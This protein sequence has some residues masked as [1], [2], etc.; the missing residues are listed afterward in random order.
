ML[1]VMIDKLELWVILFFQTPP[2]LSTDNPVF[3]NKKNIY[4]QNKIIGSRK[5]IVV[6]FTFTWWTERLTF[7]IRREL[8]ELCQLFSMT[9]IYFKGTLSDFSDLMSPNPLSIT[10]HE[11]SLNAQLLVSS[12]L[13]ILFPWIS[14]CEKVGFL[15][16]NQY[17]VHPCLLDRGI[18][19]L[20]GLMVFW[21]TILY[22]DLADAKF[23]LLKYENLISDFR[24]DQNDWNLI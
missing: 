13:C 22:K 2:H 20:E 4:F 14:P 8:F 3:K 21:L 24:N 5:K 15:Y 18:N 6:L 12:K 23:N 7:L 16:Q 1:V 17:M 11:V 19:F 9:K 10:K